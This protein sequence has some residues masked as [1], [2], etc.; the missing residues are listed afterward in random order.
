MLKYRQKDFVV[1]WTNGIN[2]DGNELLK[3]TELNFVRELNLDKI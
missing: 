1:K 3:S 2:E